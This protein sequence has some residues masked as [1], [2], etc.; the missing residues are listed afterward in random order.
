M[1]EFD[2]EKIGFLLA[3]TAR[4]W[5][6]K[7][8]QRL[9]PVGLS[10][11]KWMTLV[12]LARGGEKLTQREIAG[13]MGIEGPTLGGLLDRLEKD[14][15]IKRENARHDRRCKT[16]HLQP[17]SSALIQK[18]E[19]TAR[20]LRHELLETI[21]ARDLQTCFRVLTEIRDRAASASAEGM[22]GNGSTKKGGIRK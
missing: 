8:D 4:M 9:K 14:G 13:R 10:Q 6:W 16:V 22:N 3:E 5:R 15:W 18:I 17:K 19:K 12:H 20:D 11:G 7:L 2:V 1:S 21:P